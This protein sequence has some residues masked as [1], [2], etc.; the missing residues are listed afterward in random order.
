M[1]NSDGNVRSVTRALEILL[2]FDSE[3]NEMTLSEIC[4]ITKLS[5]AT[6]LRMLRTLESMKFIIKNEVTNNYKL[7]M[8][9]L[10]LG[11]AVEESMTIVPYSVNIMKEL[12]QK[13]GETIKL[14]IIEGSNRVCIHKE[15]GFHEIRQFVKIGESYSLCHGA[16]GKILLAYIENEKISQII[17]EKEN[18]SDSEIDRTRLVLDDIR[19]NG[20]CF[21]QDERTLGASAVSAPI[22]DYNGKIIAGITISGVSS[23]YT[24]KVVEDFI[25]LVKEAAK[26]ISK[27]IG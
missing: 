19:K 8:S 25:G 24:E 2:T 21:T 14:N 17:T 16:S 20:Y 9:N 26:E 15:V 13:T 6:A 3:N 10:K 12:A 4:K 18:Y 27:A 11:K 1:P 5:K 22:F 7:G 23:R